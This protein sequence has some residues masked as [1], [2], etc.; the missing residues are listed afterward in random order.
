MQ[1]LVTRDRHDGEFNEGGMHG[2]QN[3]GHGSERTPDVNVPNALAT[4]CKPSAYSTI[5]TRNICTLPRTSGLDVLSTWTD[6]AQAK[7][8]EI[9]P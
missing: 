5:D 8:R 1:A 9:D 4:A 3:V 2:P 6:L 7:R